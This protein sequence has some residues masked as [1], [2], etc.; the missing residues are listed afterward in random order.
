MDEK[1]YLISDNQIK[2]WKI[3]FPKKLLLHMDAIYFQQ[4][5]L[6]NTLY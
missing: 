4:N 6:P 1:R 3:D 2:I 5:Q